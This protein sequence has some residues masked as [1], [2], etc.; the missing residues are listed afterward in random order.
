MPPPAASIAYSPTDG[1]NLAGV[2]AAVFEPTYHEYTPRDVILYNLA[3]QC[4]GQDLKFSY[5]GH[6][7]FQAVP[8]LGLLSSIMGMGGVT[9]SMPVFL[10][11]FH[12]S[13]HVHGEHYMELRNGPMPVKGKVVLETRSKIIDVVDRGRGVTVQV[14]QTT[15][16]KF[17][18]RE[19]VYNEWTSFIMKVPGKGASIPAPAPASFIPKDT[20]PDHVVVEQLSPSQGAFYRA[21]SSDFNPL[22]ID[23]AVA[24]MGGFERPI[25]T[26]TCSLG[27]S[28]KHILSLYAGGD[29]GR[30]KSIRCRLT[31]A[32]YHG[33][34][35]Q[36]ETWKLPVAT[37]GFARIAFQLCT[38]SGSRNVVALSNGLLELWDK[39]VVSKL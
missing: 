21:A 23:P 19:V 32:V 18:G 11:D 13:R 12:V 31:G 22:H 24:K 4:S 36:L 7:E 6:S 25:L 35:L 17:T 1:I 39:S 26:G 29:P 2:K 10:P 38:S 9:Q 5:E 3:L 34:N 16:D 37:P 14:A 33:D 15:I 20:P 27:I 28:T 30:F 8:T